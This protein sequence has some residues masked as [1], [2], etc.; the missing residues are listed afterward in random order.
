M[1]QLLRHYKRVFIT[2]AAKINGALLREETMAVLTRV[3]LFVYRLNISSPA[4][5]IQAT[6]DNT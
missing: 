1:A 3:T 2:V 5:V 4:T 6:P